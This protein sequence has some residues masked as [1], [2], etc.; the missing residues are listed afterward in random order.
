MCAS[1]IS[2]AVI[3]GN[4]EDTLRTSFA[5]ESTDHRLKVRIAN[6]AQYRF[7]ALRR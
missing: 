3:K 6:T 7:R 5:K 4:D 2:Y 1:V